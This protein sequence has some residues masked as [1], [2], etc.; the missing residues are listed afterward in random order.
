[1]SSEAPDSKP[2]TREG[3][4]AQ[5]K[6]H[7]LPPGPVSS[8]RRQARKGSS[9]CTAPAEAVQREGAPSPP[10]TRWPIGRGHLP[11][12]GHPDLRMH[13]DQ[14]LPISAPCC[15]VHGLTQGGQCHHTRTSYRHRSPRWLPG[16]LDASSRPW[17][18]PRAAVGSLDNS[19]RS[20]RIM[21]PPCARPA[22]EGVDRT[23][24]THWTGECCFKQGRG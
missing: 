19:T 16:L 12:T 9:G 3:R 23:K 7:P 22:G 6:P 15:Q 13:G 18:W 20:T 11:V 5:F 10:D 2:P 17:P 8:G 14:W 1:M 24:G 21:S 4:G